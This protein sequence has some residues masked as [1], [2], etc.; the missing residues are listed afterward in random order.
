MFPIQGVNIKRADSSQWWELFDTNTQRFYYYNVSSLSTVWHRP[1]NCDIIPLAKLQ[2]LKQN[3]DPSDQRS[4]SGGVSVSDDRS[5][6]SRS[7]RQHPSHD[8]SGQ[9]HLRHHSGSSG[10][11]TGSAN[12]RMVGIDNGSPMAEMRSGDL[13][14]SPQARHSYRLV[15]LEIISQN[16]FFYPRM[17]SSQSRV[18][19]LTAKVNPV[20]RTESQ[21][22]C[23]HT[24][25]STSSRNHKSHLDSGK[26]SDSSLSSSHGYRRLQEGG[27]SLRLG[28]SS[29]GKSGDS[30]SV[31]IL[32]IVILEFIFI[33]SIFNRYRMLQES[34]SS[35]N[36]PHVTLPSGTNAPDLGKGPAS[37]YP[38]NMPYSVSN[39]S[40]LCCAGAGGS[41][42]PQQ[43]RK[44]MPAE[45]FAQLSAAASNGAAGVVKRHED[46][47]V[48]SSGSGATRHQS[49]DYSVSGKGNLA[50]HFLKHQLLTHYHF[51]P[52]NRMQRFIAHSLRKLP[53][54]T[55]LS[56]I[57]PSSD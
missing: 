9:S 18:P 25:G 30:T 45:H 34:S 14:M 10:G 57:P 53:V 17:L 27:G 8:F 22:Y 39:S 47:G 15:W 32:Y 33:G 50:R 13:M 24:Q 40:D 19:S 54:L 52:Q 12:R 7:S 38:V 20:A 26:S 16:K 56:T 37:G 44:K 1:S 55:T 5:T 28:S 36:I 4:A 21:R 23:R 35:H 2:T 31:W 48:G 3:T 42:T 51:S 29:H 41:G 11:D 46:S 6:A 49:F 43:P